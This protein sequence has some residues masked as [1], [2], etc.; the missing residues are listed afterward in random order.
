MHSQILFMRMEND[1]QITNAPFSNLSKNLRL[2]KVTLYIRFTTHKYKIKKMK[3]KNK[4][5]SLNHL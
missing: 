5:L 1:H 2:R 3:R 4:L